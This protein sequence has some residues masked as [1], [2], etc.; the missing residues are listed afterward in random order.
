M[1]QVKESGNLT[2]VYHKDKENKLIPLSS[3]VA[4]ER[5]AKRAVGEFKKTEVIFVLGLGNFYLGLEVIKIFRGIPIFMIEPTEEIKDKFVLWLKKY[6]PKLALSKE[7]FYTDNDSLEQQIKEGVNFFSLK[8][9]DIIKNQKQFFFFPEVFQEIEKKILNQQQ[10]KK[11]NRSTIAKFEKIWLRN[12]VKNTDFIFNSFPL[13]ETKGWGK[14]KPVVIIGAGPSL[15]LEI[16]RLRE[17]QN[18]FF[19]FACDTTVSCLINHRI[20]PDFIA[21]L[22]PQNINAKYLEN[23][24]EQV[25]DKAILFHEPSITN[26]GLRNFSKRV[27][28]DAIFPYFKLIKKFRGSFGKI[29]VGGSVITMALEVVKK[30]NF[31]KCIFLGLDLCYKKSQYHI[32]GIYYEEI[33][34]STL[35]RYESHEMKVSKI[36][37]PQDEKETFNRLGERVFTDTK[38]NLFKKWIEQKLVSDE[39]IFN[40]GSKTG[41]DLENLP[42][43]SFTDFIEE[44]KNFDKKN[45]LKTIHKNISNFFAKESQ[46]IETARSE[47]YKEL[48]LLKETLMQERKVFFEL[49]EKADFVKKRNLKGILNFQFSS[50]TKPFIEVILQKSIYSLEENKSL[51]SQKINDFYESIKESLKINLNYLNKINFK[52]NP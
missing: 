52:V 25:Y 20:Y 46:A 24:P 11:V 22:D 15:S 19:I 32:P 38:F 16:E 43:L 28:F 10:R 47:F 6:Y 49:L 29:E 48:A 30:L 40:N 14:D 42:Y 36:V 31:K 9:V 45:Y 23:L 18:K 39:T 21:S 35:T 4:P 26:S 1:I 2:I 33:W 44:W 8:K 3:R 34:F 12:L 41:I 37:N 13:K 5:E 27:T 50:F 7:V 51:D 17:H